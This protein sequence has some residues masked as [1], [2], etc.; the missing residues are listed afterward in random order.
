MNEPLF[1]CESGG[2]IVSQ[3][4]LLDADH[5]QPSRV[6]TE[7]APVLAPAP[8]DAPLVPSAKVQVAP[9]CETVKGL[10]PITTTPERGSE[11]GFASIV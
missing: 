9:A 3:P 1:V 5:T 4:A 7:T 11:V 8:W 2:G 10:P 6:V